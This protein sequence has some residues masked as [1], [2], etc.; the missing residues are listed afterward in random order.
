VS[1][2]KSFLR[3]AWRAFIQPDIGCKKKKQWI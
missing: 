3:P 2:I 1:E